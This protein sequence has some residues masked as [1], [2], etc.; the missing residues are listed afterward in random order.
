MQLFWRRPELHS[1]IFPV[2]FI[3]V[4]RSCI[5]KIYTEWGW[6]AIKHKGG[7]FKDLPIC[8]VAG[9]A[10]FAIILAIWPAL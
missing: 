3:L 4:Y 6:I 2:N 8:V 5:K 1:A 9:I 10:P 7:N